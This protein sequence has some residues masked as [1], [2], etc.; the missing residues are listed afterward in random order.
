MRT[1][2]YSWQSDLQN[3]TNRGFIEDCLERAI[4]ELHA[5]DRIRVFEPD[6]DTQGESGSPDITDTIFDKIDRCAAFVADVSFINGMKRAQPDD[7]SVLPPCECTRLTPNPNVMCEWGRA[8]KSVGFERII[9]VLNTATG[10]IEDLPFDLRKRRVETY[11]LRKGEEKQ[12]ARKMLVGKLKAALRGILALPDAQLDLQFVDCKTQGPCGTN[13]A[14]EGTTTQ[15]D[16]KKI[17]SYGSKDSGMFAGVQNAMTNREYWRELANYLFCTN[18][19]QP[20]TFGLKNTSS[21]LL[22]NVRLEA[23]ITSHEDLGLI[24]IE[25]HE[26]PDRPKPERQF[27]ILSRSNL[28]RVRSILRHAGELSIAKRD[29]EF[30][31]EVSFL[32]LQAQAAVVSETFWLGSLHTGQVQINGLLYADEFSAPIPVAL[33]VDFSATRR[34]LTVDELIASDQEADDGD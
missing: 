31:V 25:K 14:L 27:E 21:R 32:D 6:R 2:F 30:R 12:G 20:V 16:F 26:M 23:H 4:D 3:S 15:I 28:G 19:L 11:E 5:D 17:P 13:I 22:K 10:K 8:T 7:G 34:E 18:L 24:V 9:T 29:D 1:V 33:K